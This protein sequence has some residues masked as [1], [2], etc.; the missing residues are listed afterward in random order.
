MSG[1]DIRDNVGLLLVVASM[2]FVG[3]EIRQ[4]NVQARAA[5]YQEIGLATSDAWRTLAFDRE[6]AEL[7]L[8]SYESSRWGEIDETG[9]MQL[10]ASLT[11]VMRIWETA[12]LQVEDQAGQR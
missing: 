8:M 2:V 9:W 11:S 4:S 10:A 3:L 7:R 1:K 5:A 12:N 6:A